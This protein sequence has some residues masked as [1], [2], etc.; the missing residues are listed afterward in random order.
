MEDF[1]PGNIHYVTKYVVAITQFIF[2]ALVVYFNVSVYRE[3]RRNQKQIIANHVSLEV[4]KKL[5]KNKKA[6]YCTIILLLTIVLCYLPANIIVVIMI[7]SVMKDS[8][9]INVKLILLNLH[10]LLPLLN[11]LFNPLIYAVRIR[12]FRVAFIQLLSTKSITQAKQ[13]ESNI[14][15]PKQVGVVATGEQG[16]SRVIREGEEDQG[17][18]TLNR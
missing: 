1:W 7:S 17:N 16:E 14:F 15:G 13:L 6:F 4:K 8:I 11:S 2:F 3:V 18:E 12:D 9:A 10:T 5:L